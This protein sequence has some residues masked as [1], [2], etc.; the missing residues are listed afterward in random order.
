MSY[1]YEK[2]AFATIPLRY[3]EASGRLTI[4]ERTGAYPGMPETRRLRVVFVSRDRAIGHTASP[5]AAREVEYDGSELTL[6]A[7][8]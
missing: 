6:G 4:G 5:A 8:P 3:D 1:G 2:G 7:R